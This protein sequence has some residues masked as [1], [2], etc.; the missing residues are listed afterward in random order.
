MKAL[1]SKNHADRVEVDKQSLHSRRSG[2]S[3]ETRS[4]F[5][6]RMR[7]EL[8]DLFSSRMAE[9]MKHQI[10]ATK[11]TVEAANQLTKMQT[12]KKHRS[13]KTPSSADIKSIISKTESSIPEILSVVEATDRS[14]KDIQRSI[15]TAIDGS[16]CS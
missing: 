10:E 14:A 6:E 3:R 4:Q 13:S 12:N 15:K 8:Q 1:V 11:M 16:R 5:E 2:S 9:L 7:R